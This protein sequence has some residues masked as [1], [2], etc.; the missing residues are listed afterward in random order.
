MDAVSW[1]DSCQPEAVTI[2]G[3]NRWNSG[4]QA[5]HISLI[6]TSPCLSGHKNMAVVVKGE[7]DF[8]LGHYSAK[9]LSTENELV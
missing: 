1:L 6:F 9:E 7:E 5:L 3:N 4:L 2:L 8:V